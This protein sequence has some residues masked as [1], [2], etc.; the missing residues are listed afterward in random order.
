MNV[1]G[2]TNTFIIFCLFPFEYIQQKRI[3]DVIKHVSNYTGGIF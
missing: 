2:A 1:F 3:I